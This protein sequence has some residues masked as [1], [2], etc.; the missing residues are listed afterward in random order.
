MK[1]PATT[2]TFNT[3]KIQ[4]PT[5][6]PDLNWRSR[7][8]QMHT[9]YSFDQCV[10]QQQ[11]QTREEIEPFTDCEDPLLQVIKR[12]MYAEGDTVSAGDAQ[13]VKLRETLVEVVQRLKNGMDSDDLYM[14]LIYFVFE[15]EIA[16]YYATKKLTKGFKDS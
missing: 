3:D 7:L 10:P 5:L 9:Q 11:L 15:T 12:V 4:Q 2:I 6:K 8:K 13:A 1:P 16:K 14:P